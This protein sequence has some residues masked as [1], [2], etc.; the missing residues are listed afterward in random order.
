MKV[1][2][3]PG[4]Y[5]VRMDGSRRLSLRNR[6]F[7]RAFKGVADVMAEADH[8]I[9][10]NRDQEMEQEARSDVGDGGQIRN[11]YQQADTFPRE[12]TG[13]GRLVQ[14]PQQVIASSPTPAEGDRRYPRRERRRPEKLKDFEVDLTG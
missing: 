10:H 6:K 7:L 4:Q 8:I 9:D 14:P 3:G 1:G 2:P 13:E 12:E 5:L 11:D